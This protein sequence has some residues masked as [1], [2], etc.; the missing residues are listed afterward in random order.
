MSLDAKE[1]VEVEDGVRHRI[2]HNKPDKWQQRE[3]LARGGEGIVKTFPG[4]M[5]DSASYLIYAEPAFKC[6]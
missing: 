1:K 2:R 3:I 5:S 4:G 6:C